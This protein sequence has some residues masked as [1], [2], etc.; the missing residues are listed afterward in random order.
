MDVLLDT[1][2]VLWWF[3]EPARVGKAAKE[4]ISNPANTVFVSAATAW[5]IAIK[6]A[7]GRLSVAPTLGDWF[8]QQL[9][10][11][12]F[13][14]LPIT[15]SH[16]LRVAALPQHHNDPFDRLLVAQADLEGLTIISADSLI[17]RY[18]VPVVQC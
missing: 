5:E 11:N 2:V 1:H 3:A 14:P 17:G 10:E 18:G 7:L 8:P 13:T 12:E 9:E 4:A 15:L 16:A 6:S